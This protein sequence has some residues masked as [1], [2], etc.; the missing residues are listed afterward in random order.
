DVAFASGFASV[1]QFN[2]TV[3]AVFA[4]SPTELRERARRRD[5]RGGHEAAPEAGARTTVAL[6][7]PRRSPFT[8]DHLFGHL[9]A[10][11]VP[12]VEEVRDGWYRRTLRLPH[13]AGVAELR[14]EP[15]HIAC[16]LRL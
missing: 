9:V 14:P 12:G 2:D 13:G 7:L 1:R 6:R 8:P 15:E 5:R 10:T 16:R 3:R 11:A 4:V